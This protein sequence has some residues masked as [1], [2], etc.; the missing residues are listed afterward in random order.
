MSSDAPAS[1]TPATHRVSPWVLLRSASDHPFIYRKMVR[2]ID[3]AAQPGDVVN[4]YDRSNTFFGRGLFNPRSQIALRVLTRTD[5]PVDDAFWRQ[6]LAAAI[7]LRR[8][9]RID[10]TTDAYRLVHA[11]GDG[12]SGLVVERLADCIIVEPF[13]LGIYYR[14][15]EI[16]GHLAE[17]LGPPT[18]LDRPDRAA[19]SWHVHLRA[20]AR[21]EKLEGF[22]IPP[23]RAR[24][25]DVPP[26]ITVREHGLRYR[27]DLHEG[28]KT[29]FFCDQRDNRHRLATLCNDADVLDLCCYTGG[30]AL[31]ARCN[32]NARS[33]TGVDLDEKAIAVAKENANLNQARIDFV[34]ADAFTYMRQ[35]IMNERQYDVVVLDPPKLAL[36]R[37]ELDDAVRKYHDLNHL[38]VQLVRPGGV[39]LTCSCSG[40]V[41]WRRFKDVVGAAAS[42]AGRA[43]QII[44][45]SGAAPDHP[46]HMN[47]PESEY[48]KALW[49]R[50]LPR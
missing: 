18:T 36:Y 11:E 38:A 40:L 15:E 50:V 35:I 33:V 30:F 14:A 41:D 16:A 22:H 17:L 34:Y 2:E 26:R 6:R 5:E 8:T 4:I 9:L 28:H 32:G 21:T 49:C 29:G 27:V 19:S 7:E 13:S 48:L 12:L 37:Q 10:A 42:R 43:L 20:D 3:P 1:N 46:I 44:G 45:Q 39:L 47:C 31:N 24:D 23:R 25:A